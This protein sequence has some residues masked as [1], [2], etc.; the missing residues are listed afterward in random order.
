[1]TITRF[2]KFSA[3][4][5]GSSLLASSFA[6][7]KVNMNAMC[8]MNPKETNVLPF[9][10]TQSEI[11]SDANLKIAPTYVTP[12][13]VER[14]FRIASLSKV[15]TA[16]WAIAKLGPE[17]RFTT[18]LYVSP[19]SKA[20]NCNIHIAGDMDPY[21]GRDMLGRIFSQ[22]KPKLTDSKCNFMESISYDEHFPVYLDVLNHHK[23][24]AAG[25]ENPAVNFNS[26]KTKNDFLAYIRVKSG[27]KTDLDKV[28]LLTKTSFDEYIKKTP[29]KI[30]T[31]KSL[32]LY[33]MLKDINKY[34]F[35]YS[36]NVI[37]EK[38]GGIPAYQTFIS[39]K[40]N[41]TAQDMEVYNGSGY[42]KMFDK[43][44]KYNLVSCSALVTVI[45]D[46]DHMLEEYSGSRK[47]QL[48]DVMATGGP[49]ETYSTFKNLYSGGTFNNTLVAKT[50][51]AEQAITFGGMLSTTEGDLYFAV[52]TSPDNYGG[53]D[54]TRSRIYIRSLV[55]TLAERNKLQKFD[56]H[57]SG[58]LKAFDNASSMTEDSPS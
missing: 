1:M 58:D 29:H 57:A 38:L 47:F 17:Y 52:L 42:P 11:N 55:Q 28:G 6:L 31:V 2:F 24:H 23:E 5:I 41:L 56:Y 34:S 45:K 40:L 9:N 43:E 13:D 7:A 12:T 8:V 39:E 48:A 44:K 54:T 22:I 53:S 3:L 27:L 20:G 35:N 37:F 21:M 30:Y 19:G 14:K 4:T 32:P 46:L 16:H 15:L 49:N 51:S 50:G 10:P 26:V 18:R 33:Q 25:W 36:P